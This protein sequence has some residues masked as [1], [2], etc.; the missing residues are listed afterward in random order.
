MR[1]MSTIRIFSTFVYCNLESYRLLHGELN[2]CTETSELGI[3]GGVYAPI[4]E[5]TIRE[6]DRWLRRGVSLVGINPLKKF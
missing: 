1:V 3:F 6:T 2:F 5:L 4:A